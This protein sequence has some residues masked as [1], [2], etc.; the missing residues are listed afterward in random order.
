MVKCNF[1]IMKHFDNRNI[2]AIA[3]KYSSILWVALFIGLWQ[4][5][6]GVMY[7]DFQYLR[8]VSDTL[9]DDFWNCKGGFIRNYHDALLSSINHYKLVNGR[10]TNILMII[11]V[12]MPH[13]LQSAMTGTL[14]G[15]MLMAVYRFIDGIRRTNHPAWMFWTVAA[16]LWLW[17]PWYNNLVSLDYKL[18]YILPSVLG[19]I[20]AVGFFFCNPKCGSRNFA[21]C[22][23]AAFLT[24][25]SHEGFSL[26]LIGAS[27]IMCL[28]DKNE[29]KKRILLTLTLA[30]G[31]AIC[32]LAPSTLMRLNQQSDERGFF[33]DTGAII[34]CIKVLSVPLAASALTL[35]VC[36]LRRKKQMFGSAI[37]RNAVVFWIS[38]FIIGFLMAVIIGQAGRICWWPAMSLLMADLVIIRASDYKRDF[39]AISLAMIAICMAWSVLFIKQTIRVSENQKELLTELSRHS[40]GIVYMNPVLQQ[41]IPWWTLRMIHQYDISPNLWNGVA[42]YGNGRYPLILPPDCRGKK[43]EEWRKIEGDNP[44]RGYGNRWYSRTPLPE[45]TRFKATLGAK[46]PFALPLKPVPESEIIVSKEPLFAITEQRDTVWISH[47]G[48]PYSASILR[49]DYQPASTSH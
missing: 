42:G 33:I 48:L 16:L 43:F 5:L 30:V 4:Y 3:L 26:P 31:T 21:F 17:F 29:R 10:L 39:N 15:L 6:S 7:D 18:N 36:L 1:A 35:C 38:N 44:F 19:V 41:D 28:A 46:T 27:V 24:G 9:P 13:W 20:Y 49:L 12:P 45:G 37:V 2:S 25:L 47:F 34:S 11:M 14:A 22:L 32:V 8:I 40:D 23:A